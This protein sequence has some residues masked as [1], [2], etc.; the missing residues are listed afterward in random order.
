MACT[1]AM[2]G[3][4]F[5]RTRT[6]ASTS[7]YCPGQG[8]GIGAA[9]EGARGEAG[10]AQGP[11]A[12]AQGVERGKPVEGRWA[13]GRGRLEGRPSRRGLPVPGELPGQKRRVFG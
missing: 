6:T 5:A 2:P 8:G 11:Q 10:A 12:E 4:V 3:V 1:G 9:G 7:K 13:V